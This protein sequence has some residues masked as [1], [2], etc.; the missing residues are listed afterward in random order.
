VT[1][2]DPG[3]LR[4]RVQVE[5]P[6]G[7]PDEAGGEAIAWEPVATLWARIDPVK[8]GEQ[9]IA[10]HLTGLVTHRVT[11][12]FR[13]DLAGGMHVIFRDR[14]FRVLAVFDPDERGRYVTALADEEKP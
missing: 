1:Q 3:L 14:H 10:A 6:V 2:F 9:T 7:T 4:Q 11:F 8:A 13:E 5:R 12:R